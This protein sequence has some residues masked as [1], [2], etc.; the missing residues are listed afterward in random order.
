MNNADTVTITLR[1]P[2]DLA[3]QAGNAGLLNDD[4]LIAW[5]HAELERRAAIDALRDLTQRLTTMQPP[6][7]QAEIDAEIDAACRETA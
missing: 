4:R 3:T 7:T 1:I 5:L 6:L 2:A